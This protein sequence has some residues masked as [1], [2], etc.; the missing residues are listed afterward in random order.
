MKGFFN[1][2][3]EN[4]LA[5]K[6]RFVLW[7]PVL[8]GLGIGLYF[9]LPTEPSYW[10]TIVV[11]EVLLVLLYV[12][13]YNP[14]KYTIV[15]CFLIVALGFSNIQIRSLYQ[16]KFVEYP[17]EQNEVTYLKGRIVKIDKTSKSK[18][19][20]LLS[21]VADFDNSKK[22]L[23]R[24]TLPVKE[25]SLMESQCV[26]MVAT[27][28]DPM[29]PV[30]PNS[31]QFNR[32][33]FFEGISAVGYANSQAYEIDCE[34]KLSFKQKLSLLVSYIRKKI[35]SNIYKELPENEAAVTS[36]ILAGDKTG[37]SEDLYK[38]YRDSGLAHFLSI[39]GLHMS[40]I[41][42]LMFFTIRLLISFIPPLA[43]RYDS[44][45][46]AAVFAIF[47]SFIYLLISGAEI[48]AQRAF[49]MT[50][51]VL[52]GVLFSRNAISVR[53]LCFAALIVLVISPQALVS[54]SFQMSF[55]AV[56]V[57]V[58]FYE[59]FA[60][61][62]HKFFNGKG[63]I[64]CILA[65]IFGLLISDFVASIATLPFAVYHF[66]TIA[67]YTTLGNLLAG[68]VICFVIMPFVLMALFLMP[69]NLFSLP[70][71]VVG[72]GI[73][74]VNDIT[75]YV[76]GLP[77]AGY[78]VLSMPFWGLMLIVAGGLW[79]C[80]WK[81][82]WRLW[83]IIPVVFGALSVFATSTPDVIFSADAKNLAI[84]DNSGNMVVLQTRKND[85]IKQVWLE[86]T[87]SP[88]LN[89]E[90]EKLLKKIYKG[91]KTDKSWLDLE[92]D[93]QECLYKEKLLWNK[94]KSVS[95]EGQPV[96]IKQEGAGAVYFSDKGLKVK[97]VRSVTGK[98][99]WNLNNS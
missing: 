23:Y 66:N 31:Y 89:D 72:F 12:F 54:A 96:D 19:R 20:L 80:L 41:A 69:F 59:R 11:F 71:K 77:H 98:R 14:L 52:L 67:I 78:Q 53:M 42:A 79:L 93:K 44:K 68:P 94:G 85:F 17:K 36:A 99:L 86:K 16:A 46:K 5:E 9:I 64:K 63:I 50:F 21:D 57:L 62:V 26:E 13:R 45:K 40:L 75:S 43:I 35:V 65:Y 15:G 58:A 30:M 47:I 29:Q 39:S 49:I 73:K 74:I 60:S 91:T 28:M 51:I 1:K 82:K 34:T 18:V 33:A 7:L 55:A 97:T 90:Q 76:S 27:V 87:A 25:T 92:C 95:V 88:N 84:K 81:R 56:L 3:K 48:P 2:I 10:F 6:D 37:I 61:S 83:G 22:G 8:F 24:I 32:K 38:Q 4:F 70:L